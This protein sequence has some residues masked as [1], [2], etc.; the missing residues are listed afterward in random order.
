[1]EVINGYIRIVYLLGPYN[2]TNKCAFLMLF[3][4]KMSRSYY[5][6][7]HKLHCYKIK[8]MFIRSLIYLLKQI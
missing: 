8:L 7:S 5:Y 3:G 2:A 1:M 4:N 6:K